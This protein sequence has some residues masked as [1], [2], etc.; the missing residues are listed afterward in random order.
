MKLQLISLHSNNKI[1]EMDQ[2][3]IQIEEIDVFG[4]KPFMIEEHVNWYKT[5][6]GI[7][8]PAIRFHTI[9]PNTRITCKRCKDKRNNK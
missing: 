2:C 7:L 5:V 6:C 4:V 3:G 8:Q 9:K 1:H